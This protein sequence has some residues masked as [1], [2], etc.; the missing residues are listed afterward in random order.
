MRDFGANHG[1][2]VCPVGF[3][4]AAKRRAQQDIGLRF[5]RLE[6]LERTDLSV[7]ESCRGACSSRSS[8]R[9]RKGWVLYD[10]PFGLAG[11]DSPLSVLVIGKCDE[12]CNFH[13][14]CWTY[15]SKFALAHEAEHHC[16]CNWF[17]LTAIEEEG[18]EN[19]TI[20]RAVH[21]L[22]INEAPFAMVPV[23]RRPLA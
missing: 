7:W 10:Q 15:R 13:V 3:A 22:L 1:I 23:D 20:L 2:L 21:L 4:E 14:S 17:W 5:A 18:E 16:G 9:K 19:G 6:D 12:C 8:A 11:G